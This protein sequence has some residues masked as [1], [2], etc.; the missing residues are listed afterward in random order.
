MPFKLEE[1]IQL[2]YLISFALIGRSSRGLSLGL[3]KVVE[4]KGLTLL[5]VKEG[6]CVKRDVG[7]LSIP[8]NS[9]YSNEG[10]DNNWAVKG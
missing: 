10:E 5:R 1:N 9:S 8:S 4:E 7:I 6:M 2:F 3:F